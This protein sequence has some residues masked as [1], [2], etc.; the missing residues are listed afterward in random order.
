MPPPRGDNLVV[1]TNGGGSGLLATD[2]FERR[3]TYLRKLSS[4]SADLDRRVAACTPR[5]GSHLNPID[6]GASASAA[7][8]CNVTIRLLQDRRIDG[9]LVSICP[10]SITRI[11]EIARG[12]A[13][14]ARQAEEYRK[15]LIVQLQGGADCDA[16]IHHLRMSGIPAYTAPERAV[17]AFTALR[18][19]SVLREQRA[20]VPLE[21][22]S[23]KGVVHPI[24][25]NSGAAEMGLIAK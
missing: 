3:G 7:Q 9:V 5:F 10:T 8:Y 11:S 20:G 23:M 6:L 12:L 2:E 16:A 14:V 21:A 25:Y 24:D 22:A 15:P 19:Y 4:I 17:A 1:V 18:T 13:G